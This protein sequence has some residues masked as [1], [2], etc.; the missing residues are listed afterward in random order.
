MPGAMRPSAPKE[1]LRP[2]QR[3]SRSLS[4]R[5]TRTSRAWCARQI[6]SMAAACAVDGFAHA[7]DFEQ[8]DGG[9][10]QREAG[11]DV[12]FDGA[13]RPAV[14]HFAGGGSDA[15]S[16]DVGDGFGG[17]VDWCRKWRGEF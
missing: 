16:G 4:S 14:E 5:A 15:A 6:S 2:F 10:I 8:Q 17:V 13:K 11:V 12:V 3:S 1:F 9:G 7:F